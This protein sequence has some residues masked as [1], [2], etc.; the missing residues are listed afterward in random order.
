MKL[1]TIHIIVIIAIIIA[2]P[3]LWTIG[4][5]L[6]LQIFPSPPGVTPGTVVVNKSL[7]FAVVDKYAGSGIASAVV[8]V[9]EGSTLLES[10]TT[11][12]DGTKTTSFTYPSDK[13]L[14]VKVTKTN[15]KCWYKVT[16][17]RMTK[18]DAESATVNPV[19]LHFFSICSITDKV[20][21]G[22]GSDVADGGTYNKTLSGSIVTFSYSM[23]V[24]TDNTG[25]LASEDPVQNMRWDPV[26]YVILSG[27]N[28]ENI[29][30]T[31]LQTYYEKGTSYF[32]AT[33]LTETDITKYKVGNTYVYQGTAAISFT[34]DLSGYSGDA[35][36]CQIYLKV[37]SDP[38]YHL[39]KGSY[40]PD[41]V[42]L[43]ESTILLKD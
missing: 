4:Q 18:E 25:Y 13:Q 42:E 24:G 33:T 20:T 5:Q 2:A 28:Y 10:I 21:T 40:G 19:Q 37:Y 16:V 43:S 9:Y 39:A 32:G 11:D 1:K 27:T 15:S 31:G 14:N 6:N 38:A 35:A 3:T 36:T 23:F 7:K 26:V 22:A 8:A 30:S 12:S 41:N 29:V 17:P 34:L